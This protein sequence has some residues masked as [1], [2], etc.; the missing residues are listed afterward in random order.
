MSDPLQRRTR[1]T[2]LHGE[3][4]DIDKMKAITSIF[5][6]AHD[7]QNFANRLLH[8]RRMSKKGEEFT[9]VRR[10]QSVKLI[11]EGAEE[12]GGEVGH[13]RLEV[14]LDGALQRMV[15]N[16]MGALWGVAK[17]D[18]A[19]AELRRALE[20]P[21]YEPGTSPIRAAPAH[22]LTLEWVYYDDY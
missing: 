13:Y 9:T 7:Y 1:A 22:G 2:V 4:M 17:G 14:R 16:M 11:D 20:G 10:V 6:G 15:R 21:F 18:L 12:E 8:K 5:E 3:T 19:E